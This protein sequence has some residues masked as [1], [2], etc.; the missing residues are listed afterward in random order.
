MC[1]RGSNTAESFRSSKK[2]VCACRSRSA[3]TGQH[4][5]CLHVALSYTVAAKRGLATYHSCESGLPQAE[6]TQST[7]AQRHGDYRCID[8]ECVWKEGTTA[9]TAHFFAGDR[10][11]RVPGSGSKKGRERKVRKTLNDQVHLVTHHPH[12]QLSSPASSLQNQPAAAAAIQ[13]CSR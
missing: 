10:G 5:N 1:I 6:Q 11:F 7:P 4:V 9:S 13:S 12:N 8:V 2:C 3:S